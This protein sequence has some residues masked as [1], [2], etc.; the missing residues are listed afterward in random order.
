MLTAKQPLINVLSYLF[1]YHWFSKARY[2]NS[3]DNGKC[4]KASDFNASDICSESCNFHSS[5][6]MPVQLIH[7]V[8]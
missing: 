2:S 4:Q 5:I 1:S 3:R 8:S 7:Q 6:N